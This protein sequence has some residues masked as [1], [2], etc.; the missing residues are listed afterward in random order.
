MAASKCDLFYSFGLLCCVS[1]VI[2]M[3]VGAGTAYWMINSNGPESVGLFVRCNYETCIPI[4]A[5][6]Q[7]TATKA[8]MST[9][10]VLGAL[11]TTLA[12]TF[13]I[14][15]T[16]ISPTSKRIPFLSCLLSMTGGLLGTSGV[17]IYAVGISDPFNTRFDFVYSMQ[18][19]YSFALSIAGSILL[20]VSGAL[21]WFGACRIV[22][23]SQPRSGQELTNRGH[24]V[25]VANMRASTVHFAPYSLDA[26]PRYD[27]ICQGYGMLGFDPKQF[28]PPPD[29]FTSHQGPAPPPYSANSSSSHPT[30]E[31]PAPTGNTKHDGG[32]TM[33]SPATHVSLTE[34]GELSDKTDSSQ[35]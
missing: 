29:Y 11:A 14:R 22:K 25:A 10:I 32:Q 35:T 9:G 1:G 26:P 34:A 16:S 27:T 30:S 20:F 5:N 23:A 8:V 17:C 3:F 24:L 6:E 2:L 13:L 15:F 19:G 7:E 4:T 18:Y 33:Q 31:L 28:P 12:F 21:T